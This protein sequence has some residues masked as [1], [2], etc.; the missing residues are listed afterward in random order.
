L[1]LAGALL[2]LVAAV[3]AIL[4]H[5]HQF[6]KRQPRVP[7]TSRGTV[8]PACG[9][10]CDP[11]DPRYLTAVPF[12]Q[13]S[14]WIQP[15]RAYLDTWPA[16]R[17]LD[18]LGINFNV[19]PAQA[20][21]VA[22]LLHDSGFTLARV[23][24][25]W[26]GLS[27]SDPAKFI[28]EAAIRTRLRALHEYGLRPLILLNANS[29]APCPAKKITLNT[30][31]PAPAGA[32]SVNLDA[33]SAAEVVPGKTGFA[34][35][36]F[37][38]L[39]L[40]HRRLGK[41]PKVHPYANQEQRRALRAARRAARRARAKLGLTQFVLQAN[42]DIL[43]AKVSPGGVATLARPLP[44]ALA[45]GPHQA[46]TLL[47]AP[48]G[49]PKLASGAPN[50]VFRATLQGWLGYVGTVSK[51]AEGIFGP[52]GYDLE[53]WNELGFG[54]QFL[55]ATKYY[56]A[57]V[58][59]AS[60]RAVNKE[61][62]RSVNK[63]ILDATVAYVRDPANRISPAVGVSNGFASQTPF[64]GGVFAPRG[65]TAYSKHLYAGPLSF[66][67]EFKANLGNLPRDALGRRDTAGTGGSSARL[68]PLF[69]PSYQ[70]ALPEFF[71]TATHT[72][73]VVRDLAPITTKIYKAPHGRYANRGHQP[74]VWMT[75]YNLGSSGVTPVGP[76]NVNP[77]TSVRLTP[78]DKEHFEAKALLRS[79]VAMVNKGMTREYFFAAA[80]G[81]LSLIGTGFFSALKAHPDAYPGDSL[82]GET[83]TGFRN[84]LARFRGPGPNGAPRRLR[85]LS[86]DQ[87][88]NHAQFAG[89]GTT[90]HPNLYDREVL[91]VLPFQASPTR[92][93]IP[94]YVM[95]R[96]LATLYRPAAPAA[97]IA[98][99]DLPFETFRITLG[100]LPGS[101]RA[102]SITA[103][104]P[105]SGL[106]TAVRLLSR[107]GGEAVLELAATDYPRILTLD[108]AG[109]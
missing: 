60:Q 57:P 12:G 15:W 20:R 45:P 44:S 76:D 107:S 5:S 35:V 64:A 87:A 49:P 66:P 62:T 77:Q 83:M 54:S 93:V 85:L 92:F 8:L 33:A 88:G 28:H 91:A 26:G 58:S 74:Q 50:P 6:T 39:G 109:T 106:P 71:L 79:L 42:P 105:L 2:L 14:F 48:F 18:S 41:R 78:A 75:E 102:P 23:E 70:S 4:A 51:E 108:Y 32:T 95:T 94:V 43:I 25:G 100:N 86:I 38:P 13:T 98:R 31:S 29:G 67:S 103:Y 34:P 84:M 97:D 61:V 46:T 65:L 80:P 90:A 52:G 69:V 99:F 7:A 24:I 10:V 89:D 53:V 63:A 1:A 11:I 16:A 101:A 55:N 82:G 19:K 40:D 96:D 36:V 81:P 59:G 47:Y 72:E 104:D 9:A 3:V 30:V 22:H 68:T 27:Y 56:Y 37:R 21:A 17:L 73:T